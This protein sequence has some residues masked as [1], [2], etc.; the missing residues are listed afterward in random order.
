MTK[1][2]F[3]KHKKVLITAAI[4]LFFL[5][6]MIAL[7]DWVVNGCWFQAAFCIKQDKF[8]KLVSCAPLRHG[9]P[10][11]FCRTCS[12]FCSVSPLR[13][14]IHLL[15]KPGL[16]CFGTMFKVG[17]VH[18]SCASLRPSNT[19]SALW[20]CEKVKIIR[21][22]FERVVSFAVLQWWLCYFS[23]IFGLSG[24]KKCM[25]QIRRVP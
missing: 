2:T 12:I 16:F 18:S 10:C 14:I 4:L 19:L 13:W 1:S 17:L 23:H 7:C 6:L 15:H 25:V 24:I 3:H 9:S 8:G 20:M 5:Y 22:A 21:D 11:S